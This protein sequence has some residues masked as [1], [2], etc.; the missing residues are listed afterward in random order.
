MHGGNVTQKVEPSS[1]LTSSKCNAPPVL[2]FQIYGSRDVID[3]HAQA[4]QRNQQY[5][6][7]QSKHPAS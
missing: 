2:Y 1:K 3:S 4:L 7:D 6:K 5:R